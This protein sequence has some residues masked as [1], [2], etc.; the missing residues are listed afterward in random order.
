TSPDG[1]WVVYGTH[2]N[3][4]SELFFYHVTSHTSY[5]VL[6]SYCADYAGVF[7]PKENYLYFLSDRS[8]KP[9]FGHGSQ[10]Y[11]AIHN[12]TPYTLCLGTTTE[13]LFER[14]KAFPVKPD[15]KDDDKKG[16]K[17]TDNKSHKKET[18]K[19][20]I[21]FNDLD[22]RVESL[23][24]DSGDWYSIMATSSKI[25]L[26]EYI[27]H[28]E[29]DNDL[30]DDHTPKRSLRI[31]SYCK[32]TGQKGAIDEVDSIKITGNG[33][34]FLARIDDDLYL[35]PVDEKITEDN[36]NGK[37]LPKKIDLSRIRHRINPQ[38][39]WHDMLVEALNLQK[40]HFYNPGQKP[41]FAKI[42]AKY[43]R[44]LPLIHTRSE[45][46]DL[47]RDMQG[48][49]QT[50]HCYENYGDYH[51]HPSY[52]P[53]GY[54]GAKLKFQSKK[55]SFK[56]D[57]I[58]RGEGWQPSSRSPLLGPG[59]GL[60]EGDEIITID[61][62]TFTSHLDLDKYLENRANTTI[63]LGVKRH[64]T[65][66]NKP[67]SKT[68]KSNSP[69]F[70]SVKTL[71]SRSYLAYY[72]WV[73]HHRD[74][75]HQTSNNTIGYLH[76]PDMSAFGISEFYKHY[77]RE[78]LHDGL[79]V[80]IRNNRGGFISEIIINHLATKP[81]ALESGKWANTSNSYPMHVS[82][83]R[84][85]CLINGFAGSDGDIFAQAFKDKNLGYL[86]GTKTWGGV[87]GISPRITLIDGT[88][89]TQP[90]HDFVFQKDNLRLEN[91]GTKPHIELEISPDDWQANRDP[92]LTKALDIL[93]TPSDDLAV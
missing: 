1:E 39:E 62:E 88:L 48:D 41:D 2:H 72:A 68:K 25:F 34:Y 3:H 57:R 30:M 17:T 54:L 76:I 89:T 8:I 86:V 60:T 63:E 21:D 82:P 83:K 70:I 16:E 4:I 53:L 73:K 69:V 52:L 38:S 20:T 61:G 47:L 92:Q 66:Q 85:V 55:K 79:I 14:C 37:N 49:L 33:E 87:I 43:Q 45:F 59:A 90:E 42:L 12:A 81:I 51:I 40:D 74:F 10:F 19:I 35:S 7:D 46:S 28:S 31:Y 91:L 44:L 5:P 13:S 77:P 15:A 75:V 24:F 6:K 36:K 22:S 80:D 65:E 84:I 56:I 64:T 67:K 78:R 26:V 71:G 23:P 93:M 29:K 18:N 11:T 27:Q 58:H 9:V 32:S 50:S